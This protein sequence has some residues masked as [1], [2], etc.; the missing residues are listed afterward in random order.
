MTDSDAL[1]RI[2][3]G[4]RRLAADR[5][6]WKALARRHEARARQYRAER[7]TAGPQINADGLTTV[8]EG[9]RT[10]ASQISE[11]IP[12]RGAAPFVRPGNSAGADERPD[13]K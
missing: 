2:L 6:K 10:P 8:P 13:Q 7:S 4:I 1:D 12:P 5:D 3:A 9:H 11:A